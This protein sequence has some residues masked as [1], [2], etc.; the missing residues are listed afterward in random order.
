[1]VSEQDYKTLTLISYIALS[2]YNY[3]CI[4]LQS[5]VLMCL[6]ISDFNLYAFLSHL[7]DIMIILLYLTGIY[8]NT[9]HT[10]I[11]GS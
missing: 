10:K 6:L 8:W 4:D 11:M 7:K 3:L 1:M 5:H 2:K 9:Q